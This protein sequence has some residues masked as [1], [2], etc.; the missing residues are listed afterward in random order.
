MVCIAIRSTSTHILKLLHLYCDNL[1]LQH[2]SYDP[3]VFDIN[4]L[5]MFK[6]YALEDNYNYVDECV[7]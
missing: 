6:M 5:S 7:I 1:K 3:T 4:R 2:R